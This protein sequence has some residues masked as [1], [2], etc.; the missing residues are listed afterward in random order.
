VKKERTRGKVPKQNQ[1]KEDVRKPP[2]GITS[3]HKRLPASRDLAH[4]YSVF[5]SASS[6][7][8]GWMAAVSPAGGSSV[9]IPLSSPVFFES[10]RTQRV[11]E[12]GQH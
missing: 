3:S 8:E 2:R 9:L 4:V 12:G 7:N 5:F 10:L 6:T 11:V 1:K